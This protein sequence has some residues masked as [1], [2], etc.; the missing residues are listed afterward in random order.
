MKARRLEKILVVDDDHDILTILKYCLEKIK[1]FVV[2]CADSGSAALQ[3][4]PTFM[5]DLIL[6][7][8]IMP[9]EDGIATYRAFKQIAALANT[10]IFFITA[11]V[12]QQKIHEALGDT[13]IHVLLK[14]FDP[15]TIGTEIQAL[16]DNG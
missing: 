4:A 15:L 9:K 3:I 16:W 7:D 10:P 13:T 8:V 2:Q 11:S 6:L 5:P 1:G 14:P 12:Y